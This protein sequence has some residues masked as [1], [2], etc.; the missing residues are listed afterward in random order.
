MEDLIFCVGCGC[1]GVGG[2]SELVYA[3][4]GCSF[5]GLVGGGGTFYPIIGGTRY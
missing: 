4:I 3:A 2:E 1:D 5:H